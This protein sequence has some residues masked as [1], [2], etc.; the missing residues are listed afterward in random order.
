MVEW[1][2]AN[3]ETGTEESDGDSDTSDPEL[4][5]DT[6][7]RISPQTVI[8]YLNTIIQWAEESQF[9]LNEISTIKI[10][11]EKAILQNIAKRKKQTQLT[12]FF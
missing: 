12:D 8:S 3:L 5:D 11:R 10:L 9:N 7:V 1:I 6:P 2:N 4:V